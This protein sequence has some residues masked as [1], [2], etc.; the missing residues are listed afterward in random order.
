MRNYNIQIRIDDQLVDF[1][2]IE[3]LPVFIRK[4]FDRITSVIGA[5]T[6]EVSA[7]SNVL[8]LPAS[9]RNQ[10]VLKNPHL[11]NSKTQKPYTI[12]VVNNGNE[13]FLGN[14]IIDRAASSNYPDKISLRIL[15]E[16][17]GVWQ[18]LEGMSL[19]EVNMDSN[20][21]TQ[22]EITE[23]WIQTYDDGKKGVFAPVVYGQTTGNASVSPNERIFANQFCNIRFFD[24]NNTSRKEVSYTE[25]VL[26]DGSKIDITF[27]GKKEFPQE[28]GTVISVDIDK[29]LN[30][31][32]ENFEDILLSII[33]ERFEEK[34]YTYDEIQIAYQVSNSQL[35]LYIFNTNAPIVSLNAEYTDGAIFL[36]EGYPRNILPEIDG[37]IDNYAFSYQDFRFHTYHIHILKSIFEGHLGYSLTSEFLSLQEFKEQVYLFGVGDEITRSNVTEEYRVELS[38]SSFYQ[39]NLSIQFEP[40]TVD[41]YS[42]INN[43]GFTAA[44]IPIVGDI[45]SIEFTAT[46]GLDVKRFII[47]VLNADNTVNRN[48][49]ILFGSINQDNKREFS[50]IADVEIEIGQ[51]LVI[52]PTVEFGNTFDNQGSHSLRIRESTKAY[53]GADF[54]ISS[55][56]HDRAVKDYLK[57]ISHQFCLAWVINPVTR[58]VL[59]E[60]RFDYEVNGVKKKGIYSSFENGLF[61]DNDTSEYELIYID[62][63]GEFI[64]MGFGTDSDDVIYQ[65]NEERN[66]NPELRLFDVK[67]SLNNLGQQPTFSR[68]PYF[69]TLTLYA[70]P[71]IMSTELP[72]LLPSSQD[73]TDL[74]NLI[75]PTFVAQAKTGLIFRDAAT[76]TIDNEGQVNVPLIAQNL[77]K[78]QFNENQIT[79]SFALCYSDCLA[80]S[81]D[82]TGI[83]T[84]MKGLISTFYEQY[85]ELIREGKVLESSVN[86]WEHEVNNNFLKRIKT[87]NTPSGISDFIAYDI[88]GFSPFKIESTSISFI[89]NVPKQAR[90]INQINHYLL[91][92]IPTGSQKEFRFT[93]NFACD[94]FS[95][96]DIRLSNYLSVPLNYPFSDSQADLDRLQ[97]ELSAFVFSQGYTANVSV[98][99]NQFGKVEI[100]INSELSFLD[101]VYNCTISGVSNL[102]SQV[103]LEDSNTLK[104]D[105]NVSYIIDVSGIVLTTITLAGNTFISLPQSQY[106]MPSEASTLEADIIQ[107]LNNLGIAYDAVSVTV[108]GLVTNQTTTFPRILRISIT[109]TTVTF[110]DIQTVRNSESIITPF[111]KSNCM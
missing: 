32:T 84:R 87:I 21:W 59:V 29:K 25:F 17:F 15:G 106:N 6:S 61:Q 7:L 57:G 58:N 31:L 63:F 102:V 111:V 76:I 60:P 67:I 51:K 80:L 24:P 30:T 11:F 99:K 78:N 70:F 38:H 69:S 14:A 73:K 27:Q 94:V 56:L 108:N 50:V 47:R 48:E 110:V 3:S 64:V 83:N 90:S 12:S 39:P 96:T 77:P 10:E 23:S 34:G 54:D 2:S 52:V 40:A 66:S 33:K 41:I 18:R 74:A 75:A 86:L 62:A 4:K 72:T 88:D 95:I 16:G 22:Q 109:Q 105:Y 71:T 13:V 97:N 36:P 43:T 89:K 19:R 44:F 85:F 107:S 53:F 103:F 28:D 26:S 93:P 82:R 45:Y 98:V 91:K 5:E 100:I 104:C 65:K 68:N 101:V 55:C 49:T 9:L 92:T 35:I 42:E 46:T 20:P 1:E 79:S 81:K 8:R 37:C